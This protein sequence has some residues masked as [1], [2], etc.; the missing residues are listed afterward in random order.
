MGRANSFRVRPEPASL[1]GFTLIG[2]TLSVLQR[3]RG[4]A[5]ERQGE[6]GPPSAIR[7]G[8]SRQAGEELTTADVC[9]EI[10]RPATEGRRCPYCELAEAGEM[11][12]AQAFV[13]HAWL[14]P[15]EL[16][17][18]ALEEAA[19]PPETFFWV[20]IAV[21]NQHTNATR[22]FDWWSGTFRMAVKH[23]GLT[24]LVLA[25]WRK[26]VTLERAWCI[27]EVRPVA[28]LSRGP[29]PHLHHHHQ[30]PSRLGAPAH[31]VATPPS[32]DLLH[33]RHRN[34]AA[35]VAAGEGA[36]VVCQRAHARP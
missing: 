7:S 10:V 27:W 21:V 35:R 28:C 13:S 32:A 2:V 16:L 4:L 30:S 3:L 19:M 18:S 22:G 34:R 6:A 33:G 11:G 15:F 25:P 24:L 14:Y 1:E 9:F 12:T 29:P 8:G 36:R 26:A 5:R 23:I 17:V 20:D 31:T